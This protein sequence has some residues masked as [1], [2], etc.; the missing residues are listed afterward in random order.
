MNFTIRGN[1]NE[2]NGIINSDSAMLIDELDKDK[3]SITGTVDISNNINILDISGNNH[4][5]NHIFNSNDA[6]LNDGNDIILT[7]TPTIEIDPA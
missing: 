4:E 5:V 2:Y 1:Y 6:R 7:N 3:S